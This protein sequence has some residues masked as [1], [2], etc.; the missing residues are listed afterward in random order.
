MVSD[1][2]SGCWRFYWGMGCQLSVEKGDRHL[3]ARRIRGDLALPVRSQSPFS[4][5][6]D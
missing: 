3:A 6:D 4:L 5:A 2:W 1:G